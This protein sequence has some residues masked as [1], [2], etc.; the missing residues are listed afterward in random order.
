MKLIRLTVLN[1]VVV[2]DRNYNWAAY[3]QLVVYRNNGELHLMTVLT[4]NCRF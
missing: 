3:I 2:A 4:P 1:I